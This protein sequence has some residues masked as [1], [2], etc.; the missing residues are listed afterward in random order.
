MNSSV[1]SLVPS[2]SV[3]PPAAELLLDDVLEPAAALDALDEELEELDPHAA[4][5]NAA[6]TATA[7]AASNRIGRRECRAAARCGDALCM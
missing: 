6:R 4:S 5:I 3:P 1:K 7:P 2:V